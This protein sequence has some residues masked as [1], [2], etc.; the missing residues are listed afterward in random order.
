MGSHGLSRDV[1]RVVSKELAEVRTV[2]SRAETALG[3]IES[4]RNDPYEVDARYGGNYGFDPDADNMIHDLEHVVGT[5]ARYRK[6]GSTKS[7]T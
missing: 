1:G 3:R 2:L 7:R 6:T 5:L 4:Y